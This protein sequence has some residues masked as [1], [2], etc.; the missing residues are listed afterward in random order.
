M[1]KKMYLVSIRD[2]ILFWGPVVMHLGLG[3]NLNLPI[4]SD[5]MSSGLKQSPFRLI[6]SSFGKKL[7]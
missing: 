4:Q 3:E 7:R 6:Q 5:S 1:C 2:R